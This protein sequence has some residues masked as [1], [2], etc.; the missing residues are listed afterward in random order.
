M[1]TKLVSLLGNNRGR[2]YAYRPGVSYGDLGVGT[3]GLGLM[4][5][6]SDPVLAPY[7]VWHTP[8]KQLN[9]Y[10]GGFAPGANPSATINGAA[11]GGQFT[12]TIALQALADF[13][14]GVT[15]GS[16]STG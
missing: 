13:Q 14:Q 3:D 5:P 6:F 12:G 8:K 15:R 7:D 9:P 4:K 1:L 10:Q 11:A 16:N 2:I